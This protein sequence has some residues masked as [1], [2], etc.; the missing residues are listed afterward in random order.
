MVKFYHK[1]PKAFIVQHV[2][3]TGQLR[4][5]K[6]L[7]IL[8]IQIL[9]SSSKK[10]IQIN[11]T[12]LFIVFT[13][14]K[15]ASLWKPATNNFCATSIRD[16]SVLATACCCGEN[17]FW[18]EFQWRNSVF[19]WTKGC[20]LLRKLNQLYLF[21]AAK[22][23]QALILMHKGSKPLM[24]RF[25]KGDRHWSLKRNVRENLPSGKT[26]MD[27]VSVSRPTGGMENAI[28]VMGWA[29]ESTGKPVTLVTTHGV[30]WRYS[31]WS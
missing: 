22:M 17:W 8:K 30:R 27:V 3:K 31:R 19:G 16:I 2:W 5:L 28:I 21:V 10:N 7:K 12:E 20:S 14:Q 25:G 15:I 9:M 13:A 1:H 11:S 18:L 26:L 24:T 6:I 23:P 29:R 4:I